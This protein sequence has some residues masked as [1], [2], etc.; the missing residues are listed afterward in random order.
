MATNPNDSESSFEPWGNIHGLAPADINYE[1][2]DT[3][4]LSITG[5]NGGSNTFNILATGTGFPTMINS[6]TAG[7][8][9]FVG[10]DDNDV[11]NHTG[12]VGNVRGNLALNGQNGSDLTLDDT[13][14]TTSTNNVN[15]TPT[16]VSGS[17]FFGGGASLAYTGISMVTLY[18][19]EASPGSTISVAPQSGL[20]FNIHGD[21][22][23]NDSLTVSG[24]VVDDNHGDG[25]GDFTLGGT[26]VANYIG[27]QHPLP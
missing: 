26:L 2:A 8:H 9:F 5:G 21:M 14:N 6:G 4:N 3:S 13:G 20:V 22:N 1:Y 16:S 12:R 18:A 10:T 19:S 15:L 25:S 7:D 23:L 24:A 11:N 17:S 27:I